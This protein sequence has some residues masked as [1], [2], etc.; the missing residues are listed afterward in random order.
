MVSGDELVVIHHGDTEWTVSRRRSGTTDLPAHH[1]LD[2]AKSAQRLVVGRH[3]RGGFAGMVL[4]SVNTAV[5][6]APRIH[7]IVARS[8]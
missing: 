3:G 4:G 7:V 2:E 8:R 5:A 1:L 6:Q